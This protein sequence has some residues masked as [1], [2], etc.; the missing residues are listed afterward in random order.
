MPDSAIIIR[1]NATAFQPPGTDT[2]AMDQDN[3]VRYLQKACDIANAERGDMLKAIQK[4]FQG[5]GSATGAYQYRGEPV[6]H[7]SSG[8]AETKASFSLFW[9]LPGE[10]PKVFAA[11][12]HI[13]GSTNVV[14]YKI[15]HFGPHGSDFQVN[16]TITL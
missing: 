6:W 11:G 12:Q 13:R 8:K 1:A 14:K 7:A 2:P 5:N 3:F 16:R 4:M 15:T 10:I 9:I